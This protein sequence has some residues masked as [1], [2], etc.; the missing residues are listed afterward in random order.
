MANINNEQRNAF[1]KIVYDNGRAHEFYEKY[2]QSAV[3]KN[4][5]KAQAIFDKM[6]AVDEKVSELNQAHK[7]AVSALEAK[8][9]KSAELVKRGS[10]KFGDEL[11]KLGYRRSSSGYGSNCEYSL[12]E[13]TSRTSAEYE[14]FKKRTIASIWGASTLEE[15][16]K[17]IQ[18]YLNLIR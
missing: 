18:D 3:V 15:G 14:M 5:T 1:A 2:G 13:D 6:L 16:N 4:R 7:V 11:D 17:A 9:E 12:E 10:E 8:L